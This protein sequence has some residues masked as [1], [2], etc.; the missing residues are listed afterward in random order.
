M[1][2]GCEFICKNEDCPNYET[3]F[4]LTGPWPMGQ[5]GLIIRA[6]NLKLMSEFREQ[7]ERMKE[8]GK[9]YACITLPNIDEIPVEGYRIQKWCDARSCVWNYDIMVQKEGETIEETL[10]NAELPES[11]HKCGGFLLD[12][13]RAIEEGINCPA[14]REPLFQSRW[15]SNEIEGDNDE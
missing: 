2:A 1:A 9:R 8:E 6:S 11:C 5:I 7:F 14:C 10:Q 12:F 4:T 13:E 3:G 15:F